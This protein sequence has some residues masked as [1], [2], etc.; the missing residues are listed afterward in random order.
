LGEEWGAAAQAGWVIALSGDLGAG[1]TQLVKG[2]A[3]GLGISAEVHSPTFALLLEYGG[4]RLPLVHVDLYRLDTPEQ[5]MGAG[6]EEYLYPRGGITMVE[7]AEKWWGPPPGERPA[8]GFL[9][10]VR[11]EWRG[12]TER[13][14]EYEDLGAGILVGTAQRGPGG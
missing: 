7:W 10:R 9:R 13:G 1:K 3:R 5:V 8:P 4:G 11:I 2:V 6:L 12:E 14:I